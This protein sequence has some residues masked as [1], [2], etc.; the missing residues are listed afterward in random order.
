MVEDLDT[1]EQSYTEE[2]KAQLLLR[3]VHMLNQ[4]VRNAVKEQAQLCQR[5][6]Q[7]SKIT[8]LPNGT[9]SIGGLLDD[10]LVLR[11]ALQPDP[12]SPDEKQRSKSLIDRVLPPE[13]ERKEAETDEH[14]HY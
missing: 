1:Y 13:L 12:N 5:L 7:Y 2:K 6:P 4:M 3:A 8:I 9:E 14:E 10:L 11:F